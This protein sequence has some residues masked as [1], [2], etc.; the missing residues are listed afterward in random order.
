[1]QA[2]KVAGT[3]P[4][5][6][7]LSCSLT[8]QRAIATK[9][10]PLVRRATREDP[11]AWVQIVPRTVLRSCHTHSFECAVDITD[12]KLQR[13]QQTRGICRPRPLMHQSCLSSEAHDHVRD[14]GLL[15]SGGGRA[16][17]E[18]FVTEFERDV[19]ISAE[20]RAIPDVGGYLDILRRGTRFFTTER[21]AGTTQTTSRQ[22]SHPQGSTFL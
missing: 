20:V 1:M 18:Q 11:G 22:S 17:T 9:R 19:R 12:F 10:R 13:F 14:W 6:M 16:A 2:E 7:H 21:K 5:T 15:G 4:R 3:T 8:L